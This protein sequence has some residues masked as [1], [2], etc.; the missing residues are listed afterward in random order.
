MFDL[1]INL[2]YKNPDFF[3]YINVERFNGRT[4]SIASQPEMH[5][6][7]EKSDIKYENENLYSEKYRPQIHFSA[8]R[9][10]LNDPNG[11]FFYNGKYHLFFQHNPAGC[12]W[13]NMHWGH[14]V[15]SD[16]L[17]WEELECALYPD[18][19]GTVFSGSAVVDYHNVT[20][21]KQ[22]SHYPVILFYTAAG[23]SSLLSEGQKFTQ[24]MAYSI[25]GGNTFIPYEN[26]PIIDNIIGGN[27]DPKVEYDSVSGRYIMALYL[28]KNDFMLLYSKNLIN[29]EKGQV[30]NLP[31]DAE[32]PD[33]YPL[34]I[35]GNPKNVKWVFSTA[36]DKYLVGSFD[37]NCFKPE[38]EVWQLHYGKNSY[39]VQTWS[40]M[41]NGRKLRITWNTFEIPG[42]PFN[43]CMTF[44]CEMTLKSENNELSLCTNPIRE[45][46]KLYKNTVILKDLTIDQYTQL[47]YDLQDECYDIIL[48]LKATEYSFDV[49]IFGVNIRCEQN[50]L[51]V[52]DCK[53]PLKFQDKISLRLLI[54][55]TGI[56][57]FIDDGSAFL[58]VGALMDYNLNR[59]EIV[60]TDTR[61]VEQINISPLKSIWER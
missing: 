61:F 8:K 27:R 38:T 20:G 26:N 45:I 6:E 34:A 31:C 57:I 36:S 25:D 51:S 59:L 44:P 5:L 18:C 58:S 39:A 10:W 22:G 42:R 48:I 32:C 46:E 12:Q 54:D 49:R 19:L 24:C 50:Q 47:S 40:G 9:G 60:P 7:I 28:D 15:S 17:H 55:R 2:D 16:L 30:I 29:W 35:N 1:D 4:I 43:K 3:S 14:A 13:G 56:D 53:A 11:L 33:F 37:G 52:F 21:L 41:V 23:G